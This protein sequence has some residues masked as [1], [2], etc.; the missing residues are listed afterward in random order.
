MSQEEIRQRLTSEPDPVQQRR[1][2]LCVKCLSEDDRS[3][4]FSQFIKITLH[5][6]HLSPDTYVAHISG[7]D[8]LVIDYLLCKEFNQRIQPIYGW[9]I[10]DVLK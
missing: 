5:E 9:R 10:A 6:A 1:G 7:T 3:E 8:E 2:E 4:L